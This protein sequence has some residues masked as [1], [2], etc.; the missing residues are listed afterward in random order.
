MEIRNPKYIPLSILDLVP[1]V[2]GG[3]VE[4]SFQNSLD[5]AKHAEELGYQRFWLAEH[6]NMAGIA[7]SATSL[8]IAHIASGTNHIRV[9]SG[10]IM[11][12]NHAPLI[13]AEQ[14][15]TLA[16]LYPNRIDLGLG[17]APGTDQL[18]AAAL[19]RNLQGSVEDFPSNVQELCNYFSV[20][21]RYNKVRAIQAEG[22]D[23]PVWLLGS[24]TYSAQLAAYWG[25]PFSFASHFAP[26]MLHDSLRLYRENFRPSETLQQPYA[27]AGINVIAAETDDEA[28][29]LA[30]SLYRAFLNVTRGKGE[31]LFP[32]VKNMEDYWTDSEQY[33]VRQMLAY[34]FVGSP[35]TLRQKIQAFIDRTQIDE[36]M[37]GA[38][39]FDHDKRLNSFKIL[40]ELPLKKAPMQD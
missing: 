25:L 32:P 34:T 2:Q 17:R 20:D 18:T 6:H 11:L 33:A 23:V 26:Q 40:A 39:I 24:S 22:T 8:L 5:L 21:N 3:S 14:F 16:R 30:T 12:P 19:R 35:Q 10:G 7:S 29:F 27:M 9:G 38:H 37:V 15:G 28:E 31:P 4:Q 36:L 1:V 13:I